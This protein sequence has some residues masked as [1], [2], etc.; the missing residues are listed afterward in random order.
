M[1]EERIA[2][3]RKEMQDI[4]VRGIVAAQDQNL[5]L[6]VQLLSQI[7]PLVKELAELTNDPDWARLAAEG[8]QLRQEY[9][10]Q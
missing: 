4:A 6:S 5:E 3:I 8:A 1:N 10:I 7:E 9:H 2:Q